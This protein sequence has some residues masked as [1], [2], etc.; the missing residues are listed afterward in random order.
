MRISLYFIFKASLLFYFLDS[1]HLWVTWHVPTHYIGFV[2]FLVILLYVSLEKVK[3]KLTPSRTLGAVLLLVASYIGYTL[4]NFGAYLGPIFTLLPIALLLY[5]DDPKIHKDLLDFIVNFFAV[6]LPI[7]FFVFL[8]T[9][10]GLP[11]LGKLTPTSDFYIPF[12]N[13]LFSVKSPMYGVRFGALFLEPG[14]LGMI[15]AYLLFAMKFN[16]K[17]VRVL[18]IFIFSLFT[19]S[20]AAYVLI[21]I[22]YVINL[23]AHKRL[24]FRIVLLGL[25]LFGFLY[26]IAVNYN[27]GENL[28]NESLFERL[29]PSEDKLIAGNNRTFGHFDGFYEL[30]MENKN[31]ILWGIGVDNYNFIIEHYNFGGAGIKI[32]ILRQGLVSVLLV[33]GGYLIMG[34]SLSKNRRYSLGFVLLLALSFWQRAYP[35]WA[36]WLILFISGIASTNEKIPNEVEE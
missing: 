34:L 20:L 23:F 21:I 26:L 30:V 36:S 29:K 18:V 33:F 19:F 14:H 17:D 2:V 16:L 15:S 10:I 4:N 27:D 12:N 28:L 11:S 25:F 9:F 22:G 32:Y 35:F 1:M 3:L 6:M 5:I 7:S 8:L 31:L 24:K 13:Y